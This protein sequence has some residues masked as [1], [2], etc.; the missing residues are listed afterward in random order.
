MGVGGVWV[1]VGVLRRRARRELLP[2]RAQAGF[3]VS[4]T[5]MISVLLLLLSSSHTRL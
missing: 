1:R 4:V 2:P 5:I 3:G